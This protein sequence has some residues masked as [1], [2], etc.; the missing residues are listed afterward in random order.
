MNASSLRHNKQPLPVPDAF[1][2]RRNVRKPAIRADAPEGDKTRT[3]GIA[4]TKMQ[5]KVGTTQRSG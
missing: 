2:Y 3:G 5:R 4:K 1:R